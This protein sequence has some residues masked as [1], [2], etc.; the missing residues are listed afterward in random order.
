M[1]RIIKY[2][3]Y[4][5]LLASIVFIFCAYLFLSNTYPFGTNNIFFRDM[6]EQYFY[7]LTNFKYRLLNGLSLRYSFNAGLGLPF[8]KLFVTYL[9]CPI[10][11][12]S[13]FFRNIQTFIFH[14]IFL[15]LCV[16]GLSMYSYFR[17]KYKSDNFYYL[18]LSV[19][20]AFSG[21]IF[22]YYEH[23]QWLP[24]VALLPLLLKYLEILIKENK[25]LGYYLVLT[26]CILCNYY[27]SLFVCMFI[28]FYYLLYNLIKK[29]FNI[30][31]VFL[32]I[33]T[34]LLS[35][36]TLS[37]FLIPLYLDA[38]LS[39]SS[40]THL[41]YN[42]IYIYNASFF[43]FLYR[44]FS[45]SLIDR[46]GEF[47]KGPNISLSIIS[48]IFVINYI[49]NKVENL[50]RKVLYLSLL[51]IYFLPFVYNEFNYFF[52]FTHFGNG[53]IFRYSFIFVFIGTLIAGDSIKS[54]NYR[55]LPMYIIVF[56]NIIFLTYVF[57]ENAGLEFLFVNGTLSIIYLILFVLNRKI[58]WVKY[59]ILMV[60]I[61]ELILSFGLNKSNSNTDILLF[62]VDNNHRSE[63]VSKSIRKS[64]YLYN[65]SYYNNRYSVSAYSSL[66]YLD[67]YNLLDK[68]GIYT[69]YNCIYYINDLD[70]Y[71]LLFNIKYVYNDGEISENNDSIGYMYMIDNNDSS[72]DGNYVENLNSM[73]KDLTGLDDLYKV[74][75]YKNKSIEKIE[76]D[77]TKVT[78]T[79]K[80]KK[81]IYYVFNDT[82][83]MCL[84][85]NGETIKND[86]LTN[87]SFGK[88]SSDTITIIY[89]SYDN[90]KDGN[91][92]TYDQDKFNEGVNLLKQKTINVTEFKEDYIKGNCET[93]KDIHVY[94]S[95]PYDKGW[96]VYV[97]GKEVDTYKYKDS[98]LMFDISK[99]NNEIELKFNIS[100]LNIGIITSIIS[101]VL[102]G[103]LYYFVEIKHS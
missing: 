81:D 72:L 46:A 29:T 86:G 3:N 28:T 10:M 21:W 67:T 76:N 58:D 89:N 101:M 70:I 49:L 64:N 98:L 78:Y 24:V 40:S 74:Q 80:T 65:N 48:A 96:S 16:A 102:M 103:V 2:K 17:Y 14:Y 71:H 33:S 57:Y 59:L 34:S 99:G 47:I 12:L 42:E 54:L 68:L 87:I 79:F 30:K 66:M 39:T 91:F 94:T 31:N 6:E 35:G 8:Y 19:A 97:N 84:E 60:L 23:I 69:Y 32:F 85:I 26:I 92:Y 90:N 11:L 95:I 22:S 93:D 38:S 61:V 20:Y 44:I 100:H 27:I 50:Q 5:I 43:E 41:F 52:N 77:D 1:K 4:F 36:L 18:L 53:G 75:D 15:S 55:V 73:F 13:V 37:A 9:S 83:I 51:M 62:D 7:Y 88:M 45:Y 56:L 25:I 82:R 63:I